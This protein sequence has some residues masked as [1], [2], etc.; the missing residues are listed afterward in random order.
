MPQGVKQRRMVLN[1]GRV[2]VASRLLVVGLDHPSGSKS[3]SKDVTSCSTGIR[4]ELSGSK[5]AI[6][7]AC[8]CVC[9]YWRVHAHARKPLSPCITVQGKEKDSLEN[10]ATCSLHQYRKKR[11]HQGMK[12]C[13]SP[14]LG[15]QTQKSG[16]TI[17]NYVEVPTFLKMSA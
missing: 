17:Y 16:T 4:F 14:K 15:A 2:R 8:A 13:E 11:G 5:R 7:C 9:V 1:G 3:S 10:V 6:T 12:H